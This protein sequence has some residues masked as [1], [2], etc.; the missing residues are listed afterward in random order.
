MRDARVVFLSLAFLGIAGIF[1]V[2]GLTTPGAL[3]HGANPWIGFAA[4][5]SMLVGAIFFA[6]STVGWGT[7]FERAIIRRQRVIT[8]TFSACL[9]GF[10]VLAMGSSIHQD[11][12]AAARAASQTALVTDAHTPTQP[13]DEG[14]EYGGSYSTP[15]AAPS[16]NT[17]SPGLGPFGFLNS[18]PVGRAATA[19]TLTLLALVIFRYA[20]LYRVT[21]TALLSGFLIS[22]IF[23]F[24]AQIVMVSTPIWHA[25]WWEYHVLLFAA[26]GSGLAGMVL[27]YGRKGSLQGVVEGLLLRDTIAQ[28]QRGYTEVIVTLVRAVEAKD[29][30]TRGHTQRVSELALRVGQELRLPHEQLRVLS[31]AAMLHDIGKIGVPD[32]ILGKPGPLT[33]EEY[34][35]IKEHPGR[36]H[37]IIKDVRSLQAE[38]GGVR[39]HHERWDGAGYPDGLAGEAIP[40]EARVIAVADVFDALT[41]PRPYRGAWSRERAVALIHEQSGAQFDPRCVDAL[42]RVLAWQ[43]GPVALANPDAPEETWALAAS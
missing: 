7:R 42:E 10:V 4:R 2:H 20:T 38:V 18:Q 37:A 5:F 19:L 30:Y 12:V 9:L 33:P 36:G 31:R 43:R 8:L 16:A 29:V 39:H 41:S 23:I 17:T 35:I 11:R 40:L 14:A 32:S 1:A 6:L 34:E 21:P 3:V 24:Q 27:E 26:F 25:S 15:S 13:A 28:L 22:A